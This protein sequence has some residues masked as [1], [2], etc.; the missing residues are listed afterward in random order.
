MKK[1]AIVLDSFSGVYLDE[2][3]NEEHL[4]FLSLQ[5]QTGDLFFGEG[6]ERPSDELIEQ[7]RFD[8]MAKTSLPSLPLI[9]EL[10][11]KLSNEYENIIYLPISK[12]MSGTHDVLMTFIKEYKNMFVINNNFVG[13]TYLELAKK[14]ISMIDNGSSI[15]EI[16]SFIEELNSKTIGFII[17]D[18][19]TSLINSGR[20][21]GIKKHLISS[22]NLSLIIKVADKISVSGI[23][24][25]NNSAVKKVF[26]KLNKFCAE[27][28]SI[29]G[30]V[31]RIVYSYADKNLIPTEKFMKEN[32]LKIDSKR[33]SSLSVLIHT[34]YGAIYIGVTPNI[35]K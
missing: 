7:L 22:S 32:N 13:D 24:R 12:Y 16:I 5:I 31:Y 14:C 1:L 19:L 3:E 35:K 26:Y 34:G 9:Q 20:L 25:S 6:I 28:I 21:K 4:F 23:S 33:K 18:E 27:N 17:P 11:D 8:K 15:K 29:N 30:Y 10:I 2:L